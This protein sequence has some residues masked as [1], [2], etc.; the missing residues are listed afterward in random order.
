M[1]VKLL[2]CSH[3]QK[4]KLPSVCTSTMSDPPQSVK[5]KPPPDS[6]ATGDTT[7]TDDS[8]SRNL[9]SHEAAKKVVNK[10]TTKTTARVLNMDGPPGA[11]KP[12]PRKKKTVSKPVPKTSASKTKPTMVA[13]A[14]SKTSRPNKKLKSTRQQKEFRLTADKVVPDP[15]IMKTVAFD[16]GDGGKGEELLVLDMLKPFAGSGRVVNMDNYYTSPKVCSDLLKHGIYMHG[17]CRASRVGFPPGVKFSR[18]EAKNLGRGQIKC[19]VDTH[20]GI[21]AM[22]WTDGNPVHFLTTADGVKVSEVKRHVGRDKLTIRAPDGVKKY[23]KGMQAVD[24]NDQLRQLFSLSSRHGFKKYY[25]K[26]ALGL[27]DMA[28]VQ[29]WCHYKLAVPE[30]AQKNMG[31]T[32]L[33]MTLPTNCL[34]LIGPPTLPLMRGTEVRK[35]F[36]S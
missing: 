1:L 22:G 27:I 33:W 36:R 14:L 30:E 20:H 5:L 11:K 19:M 17:T 12:P 8:P 31:A 18:T 16:L 3:I 23:N 21:A 13:K 10:S 2:Y 35:S 29:A 32:V 15:L 26:I 9:R 4:H 28:V 25:V 7:L 34:L 24:R 6:C